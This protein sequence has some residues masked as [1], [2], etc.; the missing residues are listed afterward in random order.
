MQG[1]R[2]CSRLASRLNKSSLP[3]GTL[4]GS[5]RDDR[6]LTGSTG[7]DLSWLHLQSEVMEDIELLMSLWCISE[8]Y[9]C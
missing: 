4:I 3:S 5:T 8:R 1:I 9:M 2:L 7:A 6:L